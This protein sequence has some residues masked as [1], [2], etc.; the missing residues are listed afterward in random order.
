MGP[1]QC[2]EYFALLLYLPAKDMQM[3]TSSGQGGLLLVSTFYRGKQ[4]EG[5]SELTQTESNDNI[6][7]RAM[8]SKLSSSNWFA[9]CATYTGRLRL[10][11]YLPSIMHSMINTT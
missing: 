9:G 6:G 3:F 7:N 1:L 5:V 11:D 10:S 2:T 8:A 4:R